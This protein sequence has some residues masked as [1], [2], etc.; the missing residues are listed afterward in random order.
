MY[1]QWREWVYICLVRTAWLRL[2]APTM[3]LCHKQGPSSTSV[4]PPGFT[5]EPQQSQKDTVNQVRLKSGRD[6][7]FEST[8][9]ST[10]RGDYRVIEDSVNT[11]ESIQ[12]T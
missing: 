5:T 12:Q 1:I 10:L 8:L 9:L 3:Q 4:R 2:H 11:I 7:L 6:D